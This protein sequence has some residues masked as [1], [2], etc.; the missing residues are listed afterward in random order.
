MANSAEFDELHSTIDSTGAW[1]KIVDGCWLNH[2]RLG[3]P[4]HLMSKTNECIDWI[5]HADI[6]LGRAQGRSSWA[7]HSSGQLA[8]MAAGAALSFRM[9]GMGGVAGA[10]WSASRGGESLIFP[11][12]HSVMWKRRRDFAAVVSSFLDGMPPARKSELSR[13]LL[14]M[15]FLPFYLTIIAAPVRPLNRGLMS[16]ADIRVLSK[17]ADD[18]ASYGLTYRRDGGSSGEGFSLD[19]PIDKLLLYGGPVV[20]EASGAQQLR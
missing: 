7:G 6:L 8:S 14:E 20:D 12:A 11:R 9:L 17:V 4:D 13:G 2:A 18:M 16:P 15:E 3:F 10:R 5:G 1:E 19:P